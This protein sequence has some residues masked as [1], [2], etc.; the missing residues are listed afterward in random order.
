MNTNI[1]V[2]AASPEVLADFIHQAEEKFLFLD[3][4]YNYR[5]CLVTDVL[6]LILLL[7]NRELF[8]R[9]VTHARP[10]WG[11]NSVYNGG[12]V[13]KWCKKTFDRTHPV[14][15]VLFGNP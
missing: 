5:S 12:P 7:S 9:E 15:L 10:G 13:A 6:K 2:P 4:D 1:P 14:N 11:A 8:N 3:R